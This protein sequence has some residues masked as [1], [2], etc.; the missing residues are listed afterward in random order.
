MASQLPSAVISAKSASL[1][2]HSAPYAAIVG[3]CGAWTKQCP[4]AG[5]FARPRVPM[6]A[7]SEKRADRG[8][9]NSSVGTFPSQIAFGPGFPFGGHARIKVSLPPNA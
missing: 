4:T 5:I 2:Y 9:Q 3:R 7:T 1:T 6:L 8:A